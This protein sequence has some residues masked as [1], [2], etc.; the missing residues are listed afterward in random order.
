MTYSVMTGRGV[1]QTASASISAP[2]ALSKAIGYRA[3]LL[4]DVRIQDA[5]GKTYDIAALTRLIAKA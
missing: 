4:P 3:L 5:A 2:E 1:T